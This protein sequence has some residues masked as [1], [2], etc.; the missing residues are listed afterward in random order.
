MTAQ[1]IQSNQQANPALLHNNVTIVIFTQFNLK[2]FK[3]TIVAISAIPLNKK[4]KPR[5]GL[6]SNLNSNN[7]ALLHHD[8][9]LHV[10]QV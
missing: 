8:Q 2:N 10:L 4:R 1:L 5:C 9:P 3:M 7:A 6:Y